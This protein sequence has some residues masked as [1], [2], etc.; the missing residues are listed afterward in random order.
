MSTFVPQL[1]L[2]DVRATQSNLGFI[3]GQPPFDSWH[4]HSSLYECFPVL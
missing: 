3:G 1:L 4:A 2:S